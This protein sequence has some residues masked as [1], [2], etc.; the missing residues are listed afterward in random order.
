MCKKVL[1]ELGEK[2]IFFPT[3]GSK[4]KKKSVSI[5]DLCG[6]INFYPGEPRIPVRGQLEPK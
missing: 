3:R 5:L 6:C 1:R 2:V 4:K